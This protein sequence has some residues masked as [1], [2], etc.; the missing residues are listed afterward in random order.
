MSFRQRVDSL[1]LLLTAMDADKVLTATAPMPEPMPKNQRQP[2]L[3]FVIAI[4]LGGTQIRTAILRNDEIVVRVNRM[5]PAQD[6]PMAV[7]AEIVASIHEVLEKG[8]V[9]INDVRGI[10]LAAPG[11]LN[12]QSG[13]VFEA[14]NL[15]GFNNIPLRDEMAKSF[16]IPIYIGHDATLAALAEFEYGAGRGSADMVYMTVSTGIG[17]GI[18]MNHTII[19][20]TIGTAGEIGHMYMDLSPDAPK[21]GNGHVGCLEAFASGTALG[22]DATELYAKGEAQGIKIIHDELT[23]DPSDAERRATG[24]NIADGK[25]HLRARDVVEAAHRGD[26]EANRLLLK[27]SQIV[28]LGCVNI[29]HTLNPEKIVLGGGVAHAAGDLMLVPV[30]QVI[31]ERAFRQPGSVVEIIGAALGEDVGL[32]GAA[33]FV[34]YME[35]R[36]HEQ[37]NQRGPITI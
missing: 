5:T 34:N 16:S 15:H 10:G 21:C 13:V 12:P 26:I 3:P 24:E 11:P 14:P 35:N 36:G 4:D 20:G 6:G 18:I 30:R 19:D 9:S 37:P 7:I 1:P 17:G 23:K 32:I 28:G 22:R 25:V 27:A 33:A 8:E 29:I 31:K 2:T